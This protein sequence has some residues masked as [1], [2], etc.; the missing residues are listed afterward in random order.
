MKITLLHPSRWRP[1]Q[2]KETLDFWMNRAHD[3]TNIQHVL[4]LDSDDETCA[5]YARLFPN[6]TIAINENSDV[7][8]AT[9]AA[10]H[11]CNGDIIIYLSDDF[12]CPDFW[13]REIINQYNNDGNPDLWL[14]RVD[15]LLQK[16]HADVLTIPIMTKKL[17]DHL[18]YFW[19]PSYKSMFVDQDLFY[20]CKNNGW[21]FF[22]HHLKFPHM[23][24]C[25]GKAPN[26]RTY[27]RSSN[28]WQTGQQ[29]YRTRKQQNFPLTK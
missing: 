1:Q 19:H 11:L 23:H 20:T 5:D 29:I 18:G 22:A 2:A 3:K 21:L 28:N 6:S 27:E 9:N 26:D 4:S 10:R 17:M 8:Q 14:I 16:E 13:D 12:K 25:V 15:D 7:V 24:Y